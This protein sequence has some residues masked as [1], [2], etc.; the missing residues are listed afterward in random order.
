MQDDSSVWNNIFKREGT[1][2][3]QLHEDMPRLVE[4]LKQRRARTILDLGCGTGRHT[5]YL[6]QQG[7]TIHGLDSAP[8]GLAQTHQRLQAAHLN[9]HLLQHDIFTGLPFG[10]TFFDAIISIQVIHH[11]RLTQIRS[12]AA[13]M[14]RTLKPNGLLFVTVPRL[15]NQGTSFQSIEP[16][17][18]IPLDGREAGLPHHYFTEAE[19]RH[20]FPRSTITDLHLDLDQHYCLTA[21]K[22]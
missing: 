11:A 14:I 3:E 10:N 9:A 21:V 16:G 18:L 6:S 15:Q 17:T 2:F 22:Q 4:M 12:L 13:E 20:L 5:L 7:F 19:L 8:T 1:V